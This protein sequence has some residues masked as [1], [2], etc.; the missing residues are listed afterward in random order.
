MPTVR[1]EGVLAAGEI[2]VKRIAKTLRCARQTVYTTL[3]QKGV[4][5]E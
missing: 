5:V 3:A 4:G 2:G 1:V